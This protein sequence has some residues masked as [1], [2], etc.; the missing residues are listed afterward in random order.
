[1]EY[2]SLIHDFAERTLRNLEHIEKQE[3]LG[4]DQVYPVTQLWNSLLGLVVA[5]RERDVALIPHAR[6]DGPMTSDWSRLTT[7]FGPEPRTVQELFRNL[8][9]SVAHFNVEFWPG[10]SGEIAW[11]HLWNNAPRGGPMIWKATISAPDL[12]ALS[13]QLAHA[14]LECFAPAA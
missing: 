8:R 2:T 4:V 10:S 7:T 1:M 14:Y 13:K 11:I 6:L 12:N 5:P 9:N 3:R